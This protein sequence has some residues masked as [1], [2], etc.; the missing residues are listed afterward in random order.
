MT[1]EQEQIPDIRMEAADL[2]LEETFTD[3]KT[4]SIRRLTPVDG[5]GKPD[6]SR[7]VRYVGNTQILT[8]VGSL[9]ISFEITA[10]NLE[11]AAER[12]GEEAKNAIKHT[13]DELKELRRQQASSI[14][15]PESGGGGM[16]PGGMPG[17]GMG[18]PGGGIQ[19][20]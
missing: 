17:G 6:P 14:V 12:F 20:P 10:G 1:E 7:P 8:P 5:D 19:M 16:G 4:G 11:Q 3:G 18:G 15:I 9:P 13:M 2:H